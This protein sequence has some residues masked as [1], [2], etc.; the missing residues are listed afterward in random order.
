MKSITIKIKADDFKRVKILSTIKSKNYSDLFTEILAE[1]FN[2]VEN[3]RYLE[4]V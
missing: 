4:N 3:R 1:Y 2:K